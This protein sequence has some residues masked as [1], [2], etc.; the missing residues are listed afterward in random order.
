MSYR[1]LVV[2]L[3]VIASFLYQS[4]PLTASPRSGLDKE[5]DFV[6]GQL[7]IK[8][9]PRVDES[10]LQNILTQHG[11]S[12]AGS[13][14][15]RKLVLVN[16]PKGFLVDTF[17][18]VLS[19]N[20]NIE[21]VEKNYIYHAIQTPNDQYYSLQYHHQKI[22]DPQAWDIETGDSSVVIAVLDTGVQSSH[23]DLSGKVL[24]GRNFVGSSVS[25][26]TTDGHGHGTGVAGIATAKT[27]NSTG[28]AGVCWGC[29]ILPIKVLGDNGSGTLFDVIEGINYVA[30]Y[31]MQNPNKRV[32]INMSLGGPCS[33]SLIDQQAIDNAWSKG[34]VIFAAAG[35]DGDSTPQCP[36]ARNHVIAVSATDRNDNLA[37]F[38]NFGSYIDVSAPGVS[39][40]TTWKDSGYVYFSG[41][42]AASPVAAGVAA[43]IW[44]RN[45]SLTNAQVEELVQDTADD[46]G[47]QG[48]DPQFGYGRVNAYTA[49]QAAGTNSTPDPIP[50]TTPPSVTITQPSDGATVSGNVTIK[51]SASDNVAVAKV[52][53]YVDGSLLATDSSSPYSVTWN[54]GTVSRGSHTIKVVVTDTSGNTAE[55]QITVNVT[56]RSRRR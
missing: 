14:P 44:S 33:S 24:T 5:G 54:S 35:N 51:A 42:S 55:D 25:T 1:N 34:V 8:L 39:I 9:K 15:K 19:R 47:A 30:D 6:D 16:L 13:I 29:T 22:D 38:S 27:N 50:D 23:P 17:K 31:A 28:V 18:E 11:L 48:K 20:P 52:D 45:P 4:S 10:L 26:N 7:I 3:V 37:S 21:Y 12:V 40:P 43:L 46:L 36:A 49:V 32:I 41:T 56:S 2:V 53:F